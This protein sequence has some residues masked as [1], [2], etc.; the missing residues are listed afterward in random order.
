MGLDNALRKTALSSPINNYT[1]LDAFRKKNADL[2]KTWQI[3]D[4][5]G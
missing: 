1:E 5:T 4:K 3:D 2:I